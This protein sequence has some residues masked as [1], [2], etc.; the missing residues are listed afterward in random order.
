MRKTR[1]A[2]KSIRTALT[3]V[4]LAFVFTATA[5]AGQPASVAGKFYPADKF[6]LENQ[7]KKFLEDYKWSSYQD[8]LGKENFPSLTKR[9]F[10]LDAI[11]GVNECRN[12]VGIWIEH[13]KD[14]ADW[15]MVGIE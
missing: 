5:G 12:F 3:A 15:D 2:K 7:V 1:H 8:Y 9:E 10:L 11:G 4:L 6:Q 14:L 13:K